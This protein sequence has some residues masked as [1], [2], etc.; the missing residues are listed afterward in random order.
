MRLGHGKRPGSGVKANINLGG[1]KFG[2]PTPTINI[3]TGGGLIN[4]LVGSA[5][6]AAV[7]VAS[8]AIVNKINENS[9]MKMQ[10]KQAERQMQMAQMQAEQRAELARQEAEYKLEMEKLKIKQEEVKLEAIQPTKRYHAN[11][12]YCLGANDGDKVCKYCGSSLAYYDEADN[13]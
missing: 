3:K 1:P 9:Q 6:S 2:Q 13:K 11:C 7:G 12:P 8:A 4:T 10:E 5:T